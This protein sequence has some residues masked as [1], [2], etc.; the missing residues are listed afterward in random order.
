[1][2]PKLLIALRKLLSL[3][4]KSL[5]DSMT[6]DE[7][8]KFIDDQ[9]GT[10]FGN[11]E[12]IKNL[13]KI[14]SEKDLKLKKALE[15]LENKGGKKIPEPPKGDE[16]NPAIKELMEQV[17]ALTGLMGELKKE[18]EIATY[19]KTFPDI[20]PDL[21]IGKTDEEIKKIVENQRAINKRLY[22]DSQRFSLPNYESADDVDKEIEALKKDQELGAESSAVEVL[23]LNRAKAIL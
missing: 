21:L 20:V 3:D 2:D 10:L 5:P 1:M 18:K 17:K 19:Q 14:I 11:P 12:D 7:F 22:G 8:G 15:D 23:K 4:D 9:K 16:N 6:P 13:Q